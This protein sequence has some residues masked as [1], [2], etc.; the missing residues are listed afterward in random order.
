ME[1]WNE[2][3]SSYALKYPD[4]YNQKVNALSRIKQQN[5]GNF[6]L[7]DDI[8][9]WWKLEEF[10][11]GVS[12]ADCLFLSWGICISFPEYIIKNLLNNL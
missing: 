9:E 1:Y 3:Y 11:E 6:I 12:V 4:W 5:K 8:I 2:R 10:E 7:I